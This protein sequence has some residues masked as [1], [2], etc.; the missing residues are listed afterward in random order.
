MVF[1]DNGGRRIHE[2]RRTSGT[3]IRFDEKRTNLTR[4]ESPDRRSGKDRR[5]YSGFRALAGYD[6]RKAWIMALSIKI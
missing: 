1:K 2:K 4:R 3:S 6:R 5:S